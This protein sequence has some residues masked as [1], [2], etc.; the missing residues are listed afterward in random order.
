MHY[1]MAGYQGLGP[2]AKGFHDYLVHN[3]SYHVLAVYNVRDRSEL[4][5]PTTVSTFFR[6]P[7][8]SKRKPRPSTAPYTRQ[9]RKHVDKDAPKTS[10]KPIKKRKRD[11]LHLPFHPFPPP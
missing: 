11:N 2:V 1:Q 9:P 10:T 7:R 6:M 8:E 5:L 4:N 3:K